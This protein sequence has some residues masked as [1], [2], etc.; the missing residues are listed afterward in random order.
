MA[1]TRARWRRSSRP[2]KPWLAPVPL[3]VQATPF[4]GRA[5]E[6]KS[7][8]ERLARTDCRLLTLVGPGGVGKTRL[9]LAAGFTVCRR[10]SL[11][12]SGR[13]HGRRHI[14]AAVA[15]SLRLTL[16]GPPAEQV[17]AYLHRRSLLL[18]LDNCEQLEGDL[19]WLADLLARAPGV[20]LLAT[21]RERLH[22][23]EE[24]V[25]LVPDL[26]QAEALFIETAR[27]VN[28]DF[29]GEEKQAA[30]RRICQMV[31]NLPLAVELA[32]SWTPA[33]AVRADS[34]I[35]SSATSISWPRMSAMPRTAT[36]ASRRSSTNPGICSP[37][38]NKTH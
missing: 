22:L 1:I 16:N 13:G 8:G 34:R 31:Q 27:R 4:I 26:A 9:A 29:D 17:L 2:C 19:S 3:P 37:A 11:C 35:I 6:L 14:P 15:R 24:W 32:A 10:S 7:I 23:A 28:Q 20:K 5:D 33:D 38:P 12:I 21:S 30:V 25:Y 18:V 36:A